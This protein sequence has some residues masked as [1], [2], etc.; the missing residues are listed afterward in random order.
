MT[1]LSSAEVLGKVTVQSLTTYVSP[2]LIPPLTQTL[3][4]SRW[5][6]KEAE[7]CRLPWQAASEASNSI[8]L[9]IMG[10]MPLDIGGDPNWVGTT[11]RASISTLSQCV[12]HRS[13]RPSGHKC[14]RTL[15]TRS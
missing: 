4:L 9:A 2:R 10:L 1:Q 6:G 14:N 15:A 8:R 12:L 11:S 3:V 5:S 7:M 13:S